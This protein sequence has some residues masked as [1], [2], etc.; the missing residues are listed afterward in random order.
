MKDDGINNNGNNNNNNNN[1]YL[2]DKSLTTEVVINDSVSE[3]E[4]EKGRV[5]KGN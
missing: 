3:G 2:H 5:S 4:G 1:I